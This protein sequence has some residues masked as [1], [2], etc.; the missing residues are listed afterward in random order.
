MGFK[1]CQVMI[2]IGK[3]SSPDEAAQNVLS[4][5]RRNKPSKIKLLLPFFSHFFST[6]TGEMLIDGDPITVSLIMYSQMLASNIILSPSIV[7]ILLIKLSFNLVVRILICDLK[8]LSS[9]S[10][11]EG[12]TLILLLA[13]TLVSKALVQGRLITYG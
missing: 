12:D 11:Q 4:L 6:M 10:H 5:N 7:S 8:V 9:T 1:S 13:Q 2:A 3:V